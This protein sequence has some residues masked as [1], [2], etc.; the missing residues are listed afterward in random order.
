MRKTRRLAVAAV[1]LT[2]LLANIAVADLREIEKGVF[3][4]D[5][6]DGNLDQWGINERER[7]QETRVPEMLEIVKDGGRAALHLKGGTFHNR[8]W[9]VDRKFED[10][11]LEVRVKKTKGS[12]AG[13]VVRDHWRV[14]FQMR[15]FLS[16]NSDLRGL[17]GRGELFKSSERF[18]GYHTLRI[19][20]AGPLLHVSVDGQPMFSRRIPPGEGR[21]GFYSHGHGEA[22]YDDL[23]IETHV[24]PVNYLSVEPQ[25]TDESLV[26]EPQENVKL[27]FRGSNASPSQQQVTVAASAKTWG[28][29]VVKEETSQEIN[30]EAGGDSVAEFDMGRIP[31][32][33]YRIDR[34]ASCGGKQV[35]RL[36]DLP[37]AVQQRGRNEYEAPTIPVAGYY[38][39]YNKR[40]TLYHNT[41]AHAIARNLV[42]HNF[43]SVVA[44]PSFTRETIDIF[45]SYGIATIARSGHF[46][47]HPAVIA[48]LVS[49]EPK[50]DE[51]EKLK[52]NYAELGQATDERQTVRICGE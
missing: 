50:P 12:Y 36:D 10:L 47:D 45:Q 41:Y 34:H 46:L 38:K 30:T 23:R 14:Y 40:T 19:V 20:C 2:G 1:A 5:F 22:N 13:M 15:G 39:Y 31:A 51:I 17:E 44:D 48:A 49:D 24:D 26:F 7:K 43:N 42:D 25:T 29:E 16:L 18:T 52:H 21:I 27:P 35:C 4:E 3:V 28:G 11:S 8:A 9:Y 32:G 33:F 37:L 6:E